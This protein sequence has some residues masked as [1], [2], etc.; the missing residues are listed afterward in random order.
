MPARQ[1]TA[2]LARL[3][4][5]LL[6]EYAKAW[7]RVTA[8][9]DAIV[10]DPKRWRQ[11]QRLADAAAA[12][13]ADMEELE[14]GTAKWLADAFPKVYSM[15]LV[16]G[17]SEVGGSSQFNRSDKAAA[18]M[19]ADDLFD[20]LLQATDTV[21]RSVK[22]LIRDVV[23]DE[24]LARVIAGGNAQAAAKEATRIIEARG[25]HAVTYSN[26]ARHGLA[27]YA[28]MAVRT[29]TAVAYNQASL[30]G[31]ESQGVRY[32][33]VFDGPFCGWAFHVDRQALGMV[34]TKDEAL[35]Y[36]ISH[37][38]CRRAFGARPD[39]TTKKQAREAQRSVTE[40]QTQAQREQDAAR[41]AAQRRRAN[42]LTQRDRR[43]TARE[44][45]L[46]ARAGARTT[47]S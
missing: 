31:A 36:P 28:Q 3:E 42:R 14:R 8:L 6:R 19:L 16:D 41:Q 9:H 13:V 25:V 26:G 1:P 45:K 2:A 5:P 21:K 35:A 29:K 39:V 47:G 32:W 44:A 10:A 17:A 33:E 43:L 11:R 46:R 18:R 20:D 30:S 37:P 7:A 40:G 15:G 23:R 27:E 34:V 12:I 22:R 38:N 4:D 24:S